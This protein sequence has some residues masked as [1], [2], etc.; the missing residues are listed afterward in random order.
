MTIPDNCSAAV[1]AEVGTY[2]KP[3]FS[4][5]VDAG[6]SRAVIDLRALK[7]LHM[8]I[9]KLLVQTMQ[10]CR[11]LGIS[12]A[13]LGNSNVANDCKGFEDTRNWQF[14]ETMEEARVTLGAG[15]RSS[16]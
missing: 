14:L 16:G 5:A 15:E 13:L 2:V 12:Y 6:H 10:I 4:D 11:D 7:G 1:L 8:G 3:R 9:I